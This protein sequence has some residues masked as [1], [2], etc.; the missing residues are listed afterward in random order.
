MKSRPLPDTDDWGAFGTGD[1]DHQCDAERLAFNKF[2]HERLVGSVLRGHMQED[3]YV[4]AMTA[5]VQLVFAMYDMNPS[6]TEREQM[7]QVLDFCWL[8]CQSHPATLGRL[9][10]A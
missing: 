1:R 6:E 4:G 5:I 3:I 9:P 10:K 2:F 7:H 8:Q